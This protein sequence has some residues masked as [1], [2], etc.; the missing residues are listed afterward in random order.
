VRRDRGFTLLE[1]IGSLAL[2]ATTGLVSAALVLDAHRTRDLG[3]AYANDVTETRRA[4]DAIERDLRGARDVTIDGTHL[5]VA[6]G[7][8]DVT[9]DLDGKSLRRGE[10]VMS[11]NVAAFETKRDGDR[12][13]VTLVLGA[14]SEHSRSKASVATSVYLRAAA[15][16]AK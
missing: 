12:V 2:V 7:E 3:D 16:A 5:V 14:R 11:R 4:L 1:L 9:W 6:T 8:G 10:V 13:D 15:E